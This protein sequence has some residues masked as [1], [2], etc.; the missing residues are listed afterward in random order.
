MSAPNGTAVD[1]PAADAGSEPVAAGGCRACVHPWSAHSA[2][3]ARF[4]N[5]TADMSHKRN[6]IC[7]PS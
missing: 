2:I 4:C 6:C 5:A 3:E 7:L 1:A